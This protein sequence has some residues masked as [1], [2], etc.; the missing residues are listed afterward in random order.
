MSAWDLGHA[1]GCPMSPVSAIPRNARGAANLWQNATAL[2]LNIKPQF[3]LKLKKKKE[4][5][6]IDE[7][8]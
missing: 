5:L 2:T 7:I 4:L 3:P 8:C 1:E 6:D